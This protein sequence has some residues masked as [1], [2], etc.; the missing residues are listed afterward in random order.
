MGSS[1]GMLSL[2]GLLDIQ[3]RQL[4]CAS[5]AQGRNQYIYN[6]I[7]LAVM[8][9]WVVFKAMGLAEIIKGGNRDKEEVQE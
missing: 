4:K 6:I 8:G 9:K 5:R 3:V 7:G 1:L 2:S